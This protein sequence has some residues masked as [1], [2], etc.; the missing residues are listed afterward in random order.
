MAKFWAFGIVEVVAPAAAEAA[1]QAPPPV[2]GLLTSVNRTPSLTR[3]DHIG[4]DVGAR[5]FDD[6][7]PPGMC[8]CTT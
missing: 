7:C 8:L 6:D 5:Q 1:A 2:W 4:A 3:T